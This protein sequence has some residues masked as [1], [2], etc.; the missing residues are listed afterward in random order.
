VKLREKGQFGE[1]FTP[2]AVIDD[3]LAA[4]PASVWRSASLRWLDPACGVGQFPLKIIFGG[5]GYSGLFTGLARA[6]PDTGRRMRHILEQITCYDINPKNTAALRREFGRLC[7]GVPHVVTGDFLST[8][9]RTEDYNVIVCNPPYNSGGTKRLGEKRLHVRFVERALELLAPR[10]HLLFICPPNYRQAGSTMNRLFAER[11]GGFEYIRIY[12]PDETHRLFKIQARVDAFL[13]TAGAAQ[14][15]ATRIVDE[16]GAKSTVKLDLSEHIPNFGHT[17][18]EKLRKGPRLPIHPFRSAEAST[19]GCG[20]FTAVS[21]HP[22]LHLIVKEG[23]KILQRRKPHSLQNTPKVVLNGLGVP[24]VYDDRAGEFGVTQTPVVVT[25]PPAALVAFMK[26]PLFVL[27]AWGLRLTGNNNLPYLFDAIPA[28]YA[29]GIRWTAAEKALIASFDVP[30]A[31]ASRIAVRCK[32]TR[33]L[34][35]RR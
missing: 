3:M 16:Y 14:R 22:T 24:Y 11:D 28:D 33:R 27:I 9:G 20:G 1:V 25:S 17:I 19:V 18:F 29:K 32:K 23:L 8:G 26:T 35:R 15:G 13:W 12:G 7:G 4:L 10:G 34:P 5:N 21:T 6:I 2:I 30:Q 31:G